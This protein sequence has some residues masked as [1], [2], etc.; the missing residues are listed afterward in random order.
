MKNLSFYLLLLVSTLLISCEG[1]GGGETN[2]A[3][4]DTT[5]TSSDPPQVVIET[6]KPTNGK[7]KGVVELGSKGFN[8][9]I[10]TM[11]EDKNWKLDHAEYGYSGVVDGLAEGE[12]VKVGLKNY[13]N[14]LIE[15]GVLGK[16]IHFVVSSGATEEEVTQ[17]I[18]EGLEAL[19]YVANTVTKEQEG[20]YALKSVLPEK[21]EDQAFV[22]DIGSGNTKI[23]WLENGEIIAKGTNGAKYR[24]KGIAD[25]E[26][27]DDAKTIAASIPKSKTNMC[28]II[29]GI[30]FQMAKPKR[31]E[32]NGE[33][34]RY[35]VIGP[36][37]DPAYE[38]FTGDRDAG[39]LNIYDA[40]RQGTGCETFIFDWDS[41]FT[42]GFLLE[43]PY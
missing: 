16:D 42:I 5:V 34:E 4:Q 38:D 19:G 27:Y 43:L 9:F 29:G 35:T 17:T 6:T 13:I 2:G 21:Y 40:I 12:D 33:D 41:N 39:G 7:Q 15:K 11:D 24:S 23:S 30:P 8:A 25:N 37:D 22:V 26:A 28:F 14:S 10:I 31:Q 36:P 1:N 20:S 3:P 18:I 32:V